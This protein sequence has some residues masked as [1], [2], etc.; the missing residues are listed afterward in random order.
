MIHLNEAIR[1]RAISAVT[2]PRKTRAPKGSRLGEG[3]YIGMVIIYE[4]KGI[5]DY[6][7]IEGVADYVHDWFAN[8]KNEYNV[9]ETFETKVYN[10]DSRW[11]I[12]DEME[13]LKDKAEKYLLD[14][15]LE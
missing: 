10:E 14:F 2:K 12:E 15:E 1:K 3:K 9:Y 13:D 8:A 5:L 4:Y 7:C 6:A 11:G